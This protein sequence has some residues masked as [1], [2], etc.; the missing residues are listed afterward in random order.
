MSDG[1]RGTS[2]SHPM[3]TV[4]Y[5]LAPVCNCMLVAVWIDQTIALPDDPVLRP[6][7]VVV[8]VIHAAAIGVP[9]LI[10]FVRVFGDVRATSPAFPGVPEFLGMV[11]GTL[12]IFALPV[13]TREKAKWYAPVYYGSWIL[14]ILAR[15]IGEVTRVVW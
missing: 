15:L 1:K 2:R 13:R 4:C 10:S 14:V 9:G 7:H 8:L 6:W 12:M 5:W 3:P 11:R